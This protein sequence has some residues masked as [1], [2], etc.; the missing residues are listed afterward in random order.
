MRDWLRDPIFAFRVPGP[1]LPLLMGLARL[2]LALFLGCLTGYVMT[3]SPKRRLW[4]TI[5]IFQ[6]RARLPTTTR[7]SAESQMSRLSG[8]IV[9]RPKIS[10]ARSMTGPIVEPLRQAFS[11]NHWW[12]VSTGADGQQSVDSNRIRFVTLIRGVP[13]KIRF[14]AVHQ[15]NHPDPTTR[16]GLSNQKAVDSELATL[17]YF[18]SQISVHSTILTI[19]VSST[20]RRLIHDSCLWRA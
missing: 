20:L 10:N 14:K 18:R 15:G 2:A 8:W 1:D 17:G 4:S 6:S 13:L 12:T 16:V 9:R 19:V 3:R 7:P 5:P 11:K